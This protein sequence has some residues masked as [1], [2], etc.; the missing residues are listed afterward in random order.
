[1]EQVMNAKLQEQ[2]TSIGGTYLR[3]FITGA[4]T[5]YTLGKTTPK[6]FMAAGLAAIIPLVMR[7]ANPKDSFP[8]KK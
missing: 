1:M 6:D 3:A 2:L 5:A 8:L 4:V 7:W